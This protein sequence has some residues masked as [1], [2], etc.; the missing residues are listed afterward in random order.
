MKNESCLNRRVW[1]RFFLPESDDRVDPSFD[2]LYDSYGSNR[3]VGL[4]DDVYAHE[5]FPAKTCDG[6]LVT[7]SGVG[8]NRAKLVMEAGGIHQFLRVAADTPI[9]ADCGAFQ[10]R[11]AEV[12]PYSCEETCEF[13]EDLGF[14]YGISLDHMVLDFDP[15][16]D[17]DHSLFQKIPTAEMERRF[18]LTLDNAKEM[19]RIHKRRSFRF[20]LIGAVQGWS[21]QS[22]HDGVR[23]LAE[24]GLQYLALGGL[25]RAGDEQIRMV[26]DAIR[27]TV[28]ERG[29]QLHILGV[30]RLSLLPDYARTN[31]VSCDSASTILQ[32]FKSNTDNYHTRDKNYT[33]VRIPPATGDLSPKVRKLLAKTVEKQG[34][35]ASNTL[36]SRLIQFEAKALADLRA[37]SRHEIPLDE[38]MESLI[39]YEDEFGDDKRYYPRFEETLRDRPWEH[40]PC[41]ICKEIGIEVIILRGN[42]RNRRR[43]FHN[44]YV[45]Y[46]RFMELRNSLSSP[47]MD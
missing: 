17:A 37:Y 44:T 21:P 29:V 13:Y 12:P 6:I 43:G 1:P 26:L 41:A 32:A 7:R 42:N 16:Y 19:H 40:C 18:R 28:V 46:E 27:S 11:S 31:V 25:A 9:I 24:A 2:F 20:N 45:F 8:A 47:S 5:I 34:K 38:A 30:A 33:A 10:Y 3:T 15:A 39:A 22:Y 14:N 35:V 4:D 23:K 36:H